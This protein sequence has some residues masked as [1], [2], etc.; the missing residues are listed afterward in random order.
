MLNLHKSKESH[1]DILSLSGEVDASNSV[2]LD[3]AIKELVEEGAKVILVDGQ[4]LEYISSAGL[5]VFM[6]YLEDF[7]DQ[8]IR[9]V[10]FG[11]SPR[12]YEV[13]KILGLD[14]L[15]PIV[16]DKSTAI[17]SENEV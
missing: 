8:G 12:V 4:N 10:I 1:F 17:A 3:H 7:Q 16:E 15:I 2:I 13:F 9:L 11:L 14:Q 5:G 6:S